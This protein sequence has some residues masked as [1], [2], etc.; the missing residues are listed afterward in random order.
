MFDKNTEWDNL[1]DDISLPN[2]LLQDT[3]LLNREQC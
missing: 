3:T 1:T 2:A